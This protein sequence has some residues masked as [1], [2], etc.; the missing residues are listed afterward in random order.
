MI[1]HR[2]T[3]SFSLY[4]NM[5]NREKKNNGYFLSYIKQTYIGIKGSDEN[6]LTILVQNSLDEGVFMYYIN[7]ALLI[8]N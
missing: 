6:S 5:T 1:F 8:F 2:K 7:R 4:I 3:V